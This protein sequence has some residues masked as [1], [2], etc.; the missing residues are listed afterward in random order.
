MNRKAFTLIEMLVVVIIIMIL[1]SYAIF[2]YLDTIKE[3]EV[4]QAK[5]KL[6]VLNA[7]Y[8]RFLLEYPNTTG[9]SSAI[10]INSNY[11]SNCTN[12]LTGVVR[13]ASCGYIPKMNFTAE[14]YNYIFMGT[15]C[16]A[17]NSNDTING[18]VIMKPKDPADTSLGRFG[19]TYCAGIDLNKGGKAVDGTFQ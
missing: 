11:G 5:T 8:E 9:W 2:A 7:G 4:K 15:G 17:S 6:E 13:L 10:F 18:Y 16:G 19:G 14:K 3:G 12:A 1:A